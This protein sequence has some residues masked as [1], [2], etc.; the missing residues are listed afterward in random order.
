MLTPL[1]LAALL[2]LLSVARAQEAPSPDT[3]TPADPDASGSGVLYTSVAGGAITVLVVCTVICYADRRSMKRKYE[4]RAL[5]AEQRGLASPGR[6]DGG[7]GGGSAA[8]AVG[9]ATETA[10]AV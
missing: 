7:G 4:I 10:A 3:A 5:E 9:S 2:L 8:A 6:G 1:G